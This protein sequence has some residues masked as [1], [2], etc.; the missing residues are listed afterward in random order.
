MVSTRRDA[1]NRCMILDRLISALL[2]GLSLFIQQGP[3]SMHAPVVTT[4]AAITTYHPMAGYQNTDA[5]SGAC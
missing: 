2:D 1:E 5:V 4:Q 3:F